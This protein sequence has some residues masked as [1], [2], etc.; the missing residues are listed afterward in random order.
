MNETISPAIVPAVAGDPEP[1]TLQAIVDWM[2]LGGPI[3]WVLA[4]MATLALAI[5][6]LKMWQFARVGVGSSRRE[7]HALAHWRGGE[8][9]TALEE[10]GQC[11]TP[12]AH[13]LRVAMR[14]VQSNAL[15][16]AL[17]R[18]EVA[19]VA[20]SDL[21]DLR[22]YLRPL[23][24]IGTAA[25]LLG[26]LGTVLGMIDAFQAIQGAGSQVDPALLSGGIWE[27]LLTTAVGLSLAIP[28]TFAHGWLE[29]RVERHGH[30]IEDAV[31]QVFT[32]GHGDSIEDSKSGRAARA[33][34]LA[35]IGSKNAS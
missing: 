23:E 13:V 29:R 4:A 21:E 31:T 17:L 34:S 30:L 2:N 8:R 28:I 1:T 9:Q 19:R 3:V 5:V 32:G 35:V 16:D 18:E 26:L 33:A 14:G 22:H 10:L 25:P 12:L 27:A 20:Q 6:L 11:N 24:V 7:M 15:P